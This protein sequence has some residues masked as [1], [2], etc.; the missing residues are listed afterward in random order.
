MLRCLLVHS[1]F[2][3]VYHDDNTTYENIRS[4]KRSIG[5]LLE[6]IN[7]WLGHESII[8]VPLSSKM[9]ESTR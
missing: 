2:Y 5:M 6:Y 9:W 8:P 4:S 1:F 7:R 3:I